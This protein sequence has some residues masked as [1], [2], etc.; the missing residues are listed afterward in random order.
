MTK[1]NGEQMNT[2]QHIEGGAL[3]GQQL[4]A[5]QAMAR[6]ANADCGKFYSW[7]PDILVS[8]NHLG[9]QARP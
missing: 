4:V 5:V 6:T 2:L 8:F 9:I 1:R 7:F 3:Y